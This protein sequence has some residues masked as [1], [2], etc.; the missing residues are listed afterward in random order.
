M[1]DLTAHTNTPGKDRPMPSTLR[2]DLRSFLRDWARWSSAER[3]SATLLLILVAV[4][5]MV[6]MVP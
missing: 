5:P 1:N 4:A 3:R 6:H 2:R